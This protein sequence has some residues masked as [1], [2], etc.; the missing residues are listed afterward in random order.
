MEKL[1]VWFRCMGRMRFFFLLG[2]LLIA[3]GVFILATSPK[4][5]AETTAVVTRCE[6]EAYDPEEGERYEVRFEY[7]VDGKRYEN[8]FGSMASEMRPGEELKIYYDPAKPESV[9]NTKHGGVIAV[10]L[11]VLGAAAL[12]FASWRAT[13]AYKELN[14]EE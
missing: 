14:S 6:R 11:L 1:I 4:E 12:G 13:R 10:V 8:S 3:A 7:T 5:Y 9:T 2:L